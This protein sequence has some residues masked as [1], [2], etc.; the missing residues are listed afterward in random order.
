MYNR[1]KTI[2]KTLESIYNSNYKDFEVI[3]VDDGSTD[4]SVNV[5]QKYPCKIIKLP[6]NKGA[7]AARNIGAKK[8]KG[9]TLLFIDSDAIINK[10]TIQKIAESKADITVGT[11]SY[12]SIYKNPC[13]LYKSLFLYFSHH[14]IPR[15]WSG[16]GAIKKNIFKDFQF[17]ESE[18]DNEDTELGIRLIKK[19]YKIDVL[20]DVCVIHNHK[21]NIFSLIKNDFRKGKNLIRTLI[22]QKLNIDYLRHLK[23]FFI[24]DTPEQVTFF[25]TNKCNCR[26][27]HCF[28]QNLNKKEKELT[29]KEIET[30][31]KGLPKFIYLLIGGGEPFIRKDLDK[32]V[33]LFYVNN[34]VLNTSISTNGFY[35]ENIVKTVKEILSKYNHHLVVNVSIDAVGKDHDAI[36]RAPVFNN[37]LKTIEE[38][39]KI[40]NKNFNVGVIITMSPYNQTKLKEV[41]NYVKGLGVDSISL[42]YM[43]GA[44]ADMEKINMEVRYYDEMREIIKKDLKSKE[45]KGHYSFLFSKMNLA[46]K[47][48]MRE[49]I[50][51]MVKKG[52]QTP[53]YAGKLNC[54]ITNIGKVYP[55]EMLDMCMGDLRKESFMKIWNSPNSKKIRKFIKESKCYCTEECNT[56]MNLLFNLK[57]SPKLIMEAMS[58]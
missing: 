21:Y 41:Y 12:K 16:C 18:K 52:Y 11:Y 5:V 13:S 47:I 28:V 57:Y 10:D 6:K 45:V 37:A 32:I 26:C 53:C 8:A 42:N 2:S 35:T 4:N 33:N 39:K 22:K 27:K 34:N 9:D 25:V 58:L 51:K 56:N 14:L 46:S 31:S 30:I 7:G 43:R 54:I 19:G 23:K 36:R 49:Y 50:S 29:L 3:V 55:C 24:K 17:D 20:K 38:L 44:K 1:E 40:K 15:F 48:K